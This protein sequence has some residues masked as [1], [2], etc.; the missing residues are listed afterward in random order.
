MKNKC[1]AAAMVA[2]MSV[3]VL[4]CLSASAAGYK[5]GDVN[6]NDKIDGVDASDINAIVNKT[7][8]K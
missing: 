7:M 5:L 1:I 2:L 8:G 6:N 3:S 4:G